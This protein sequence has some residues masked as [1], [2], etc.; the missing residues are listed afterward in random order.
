MDRSKGA[1]RLTFTVLPAP[2]CIGAATANMAQTEQE[3]AYR[4]PSVMGRGGLLHRYRI[5][6]EYSQMSEMAC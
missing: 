4:F 1:R 6:L 3:G 5:C 2:V